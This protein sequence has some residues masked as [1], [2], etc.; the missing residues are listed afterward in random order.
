VIVYFKAKLLKFF[1]R[2]LGLIGFSPNYGKAE[3]SFRV[4]A[5]VV[6]Q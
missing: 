3:V 2:K 4:E 5:H 1:L 6:E